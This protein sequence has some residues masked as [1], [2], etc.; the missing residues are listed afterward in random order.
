MNKNENAFTLLEL[1]IA[2]SIGTALILIVSLSV[3]MGFSHMERG[4]S[5]IDKNHREKSAIHFFSQQV[6]SAINKVIEDE[7]VFQGSSDSLLFV[8]PISL[9]KRYGLGLMTVLYS[10]EE[11]NRGVGLVYREKR[12]IPDENTDEFKDG[13][14]IMPDSSDS[15]VIFEECEEITFEYLDVQGNE[16][17]VA[18]K[19]KINHE[20]KETWQE[21]SLPKAVKLTVLK[22]GQSREIIAPI[23]VMY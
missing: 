21:N 9:K 12:F 13:S 10:L 19:D 5:W 23:M 17:E 20:W 14:N 2:L 4:T 8:T 7:V 1:I 15:V 3:K 22:D 18:T 16:I 6:S 11:D